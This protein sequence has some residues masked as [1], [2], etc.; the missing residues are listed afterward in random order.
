VTLPDHGTKF[1]RCICSTTDYGETVEQMWLREI[2]CRGTTAKDM[3][4]DLTQG[5]EESDNEEDIEFLTVELARL[6]KMRDS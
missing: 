6:K 5:L 1:G 2:D 3:I 4:E